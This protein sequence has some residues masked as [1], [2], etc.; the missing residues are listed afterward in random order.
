MPALIP[1][2][3]I[4]EFRDL[5]LS[6]VSLSEVGK[7]FGRG[8]RWVQE[9]RDQLG[10][11]LR[12]GRVS[13]EDVS[14]ALSSSS[15][16]LEQ[17]SRDL[18]VARDIVYEVARNVDDHRTHP[19]EAVVEP[20]SGDLVRVHWNSVRQS[21]SVLTHSGSASDP[22]PW[23]LWV[24][25]HRVALRDARLV[26]V[27]DRWH[28]RLILGGRRIPAVIEGVTTCW[29][30]S[31]VAGIVECVGSRAGDVFLESGGRGISQ[32]SLV[33]CDPCGFVGCRVD[34]DQGTC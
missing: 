32:S 22:V 12:V 31:G 24:R 15:S 23:R 18:G 9:I 20:T 30:T 11:P 27:S 1:D 4:Q 21:W 13:R 34:V 2:D 26:V 25:A 7:R 29:L 17:I 33:R 28:Q 16:S 3:R 19:A 10:L 14:M 5:Y 6:G 8:K